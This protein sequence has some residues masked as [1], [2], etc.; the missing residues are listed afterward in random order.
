MDNNQQS[1]NNNAQDSRFSVPS[2]QEPQFEAKEGTVSVKV[3]KRT[4]ISLTTRRNLMGYWFILP[5]LIGL[6]FIYAPSFVEAIMYSFYTLKFEGG[7]SLV[8]P[9][10]SYYNQILFV[11]PDFLRGIFESTGTMFLNVVI[12]LIYSLIIA[13]ILN[14]NIGAKGF[15]RAILFLPVI[16]ATGIIT[17]VDNMDLVRGSAALSED[18]ASVASGLFSEFDITILLESLNLSP[19]LTEIVSNA[20]NNIY[21]IITSSGVQLIIFLAGLQSISPAVYESAT[22]EGATWWESFWKITIPMISPLILVNLVYTVV[23]SFTRYGNVVMDGI[24]QDIQDASYSVASAKSLVYLLIVGIFLGIV[25]AIT[26]R[27]VFYENK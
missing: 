12:I 11:D 18:A 4:K 15:Y 19:S 22:V 9:G 27:F 3:P 25:V 14:R 21:T 6:V 26:N 13:T 20:V 7:L 2:Q 16:V 24:F 8:D 5:F 23:D 1:V 10:L 17:K